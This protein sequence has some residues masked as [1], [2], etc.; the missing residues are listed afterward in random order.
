MTNNKLVANLLKQ[1]QYVH[2][3]EYLGP[4]V[5]RSVLFI[6]QFLIPVISLLFVRIRQKRENLYKSKTHPSDNV[7]LYK[8]FFSLL[9]WHRD[10]YLISVSQDISWIF[11]LNAFL[12]GIIHPWTLLQKWYG[13]FCFHPLTGQITWSK[14][15]IILYHV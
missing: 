5:T 9:Q 14:R 1:K 15:C 12:D 10:N 4:N 7:I 2:C 11:Y 13:E 3:W 8:D 6:C